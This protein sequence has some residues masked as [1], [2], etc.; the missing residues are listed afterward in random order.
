MIYG[1]IVH[2]PQMGGLAFTRVYDGDTILVTTNKTWDWQLELCSDAMV[3]C[4]LTIT[5]D[6]AAS[7]TIHRL[8][9]IKISCKLNAGAGDCTGVILRDV[10]IVCDA[11]ALATMGPLQISGVG[12]AM[13]IE[14]S[15]LYGC[16]SI[17]DGGSIRV[18][19]GGTVHV[20]GS[21]IQRSSSQVCAFCCASRIIVL[22]SRVRSLNFED[23]CRVTEEPWLLS[24]RMLRYRPPPL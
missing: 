19:G 7:S 15:I 21:R 11:N 18:Y 20:S 14:N 5:G 12:L 17:K 3:P 2:F 24:G 6:P 10:T 16:A 22:H 8:S 9:T 23:M 13:Y 1:Q 4:G